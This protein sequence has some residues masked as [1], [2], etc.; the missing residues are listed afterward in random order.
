M[1]VG[2]PRPQ[3]GAGSQVLASSHCELR[4]SKA[5]VVSVAAKGRT[6]SRQVWSG[7]ASGSEPLMTCRNPLGDVGT[8][9][10]TFSWDQLGVALKPAWAASGR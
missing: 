5:T 10:A 8:G 2:P 3:S 9:G 1:G 4:S 7:E 6:R